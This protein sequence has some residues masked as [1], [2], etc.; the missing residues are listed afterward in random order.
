MPV[1][2]RG[3]RK[4]LSPQICCKREAYFCAI[5]ITPQTFCCRTVS[6]H[7]YYV[8][9]YCDGAIFL[10]KSL[11]HFLVVA[12][13]IWA[14]QQRIWGPQNFG[15]RT[16]LLYWIKHVLRYVP[17]ATKPVPPCTLSTPLR[18]WEFH[19]IYTTPMQ[20]GTKMYWLHFEIERS[21]VK[22]TN[23]LFRRRRTDWR[24][25]VDHRP[26]SYNVI[27]YV[28]YATKV[29]FLLSLPQLQI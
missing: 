9:I 23:A 20:L 7:P 22:V 28:P 27:Y 1:H 2:N 15:E 13:K 10:Q 14:P 18:L 4:G 11:R 29:E 25:S 8:V 6:L 16:V 19:Q 5:F 24:F 12:L 26:L 3:G 21:K 17:P